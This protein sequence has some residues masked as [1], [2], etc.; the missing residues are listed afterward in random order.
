ML[1]TITVVSF[2]CRWER[3]AE[4]L[5][6]R[7]SKPLHVATAP[8]WSS[9]TPLTPYFHS[10]TLSLPAGAAH[11]HH[12]DL[13]SRQ[14]AMQTTVPKACQRAVDVPP[15]CPTP[16]SVSQAHA[17]IMQFL[18]LFV[19]PQPILSQQ[20]PSSHTCTSSSCSPPRA[21]LYACSI[22]VQYAAWQRGGISRRDARIVNVLGME[23]ARRLCSRRLFF[24]MLL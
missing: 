14:A 3:D 19:T 11:Q 13:T 10:A 16:F 23:T 22:H 20:T 6:S 4:S 24:C 17:H 18:S 21:R 1:L 8:P 5:D 2:V 7:R 9:H 12:V 15:P